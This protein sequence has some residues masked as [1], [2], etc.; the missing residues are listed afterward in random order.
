M[1]IIINLYDL[2]NRYDVFQIF[3]LFFPLREFKF[4]SLHW[5]YK[6][7][8]DENTIYIEDEIGIEIYSINKEIN[9]KEELK[10]SIYIFLKKRTGKDFPWGTMLGIRPSKVALSLLRD[11]KDEGE[12]VS[13]F[14]KHYLA[15]EEKAKLCIEIARVENSMVNNSKDKISLYIG[16]P[17]CP[18]RCSYCSFASNPI[19][20]FKK[21]VDG[22]IKALT[23]EI[24]EINKF[25]KEK[26]LIIQTLY[27]GGGTP[28]A[29]G[30]EEF[31][32]IMEKIY[33]NF[34]CENHIEEFTVECGRPDSLSVDKF[35]TMKK[36][37][38]TRISINPQTMNDETLKLIGRN[39]TAQDV[40]ESYKIAREMGFDNINM[41]IIVGLPG[42][43]LSHI[44]NTCKEI[45]DLKPDSIT[46]HGMA[47]KKGSKL[48]EK[49]EEYLN[50][51]HQEELNLMYEE[52]FEL[53]KNL[54]MKPYY[55]YRQKNM[56]GN[57]ENI[58]YALGGK[59]CIYN[60]QMI[61]EK[62]T[63]IALGADGI[64]KII[65]LDSNKIE[66]APNVK[67]VIEYNNR[68]DEMI[69][70]K[71]EELKKLY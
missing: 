19:G 64:T 14:K 24:E 35:S 68:V 41:D 29:I 65:Y 47:I 55:M 71:I 66:R 50:S 39:H 4:D 21:H 13:Y 1:E 48:L 45:Y 9:F 36:Y 34:V 23:K 38:V 31:S 18:T 44:K 70:K 58:G 10:K 32:Y 67:D 22:Y 60:I 12:I 43:R 16:M 3:N 63:I 57:M 52:T 2:K 7:T 27:F 51:I 59:E 46:V 61:E 17:F 69:N 42:E 37:G 30:E 6:I 62:Q 56:V 40:K 28:T 20:S 54:K 53:S 49:L 8:Q 15:E 26:R 5:N 25:I 33:N 11:G